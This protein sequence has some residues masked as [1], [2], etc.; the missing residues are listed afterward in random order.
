MKKELTKDLMLYFAPEFPKRFSTKRFRH[1]VLLGIG[2]NIG[3]TPRRFKK[4]LQMLKNNPRIRVVRSAPLL[5]NPPFGYLEQK[6]FFNS[7]LLVDTSL[8]P[9]ALLHT[10]LYLEKRFKRKRTFK[11]APRTLDIDIIFYDDIV[12]HSKDLTIP[13]PHW[14]ERESVLIPL[15]FLEAR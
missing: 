6:E 8:S 13:H 5:K 15:C 3:N 7:L 1:Q 9:R 12:M 11:N 4:L 10:L 14:F 2:G